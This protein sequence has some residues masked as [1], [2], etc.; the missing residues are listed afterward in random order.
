[1]KKE[2]ESDLK[3]KKPKN[4]TFQVFFLKTRFFKSVLRLGGPHKARTDPHYAGHL[5]GPKM[6]R[7]K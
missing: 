2:K 1:M 5:C 3:I 6:A 7:L 4:L